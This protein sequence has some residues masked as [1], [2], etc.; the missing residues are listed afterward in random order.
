[1]AK[2]SHPSMKKNEN[3]KAT[4]IPTHTID[5]AEEEERMMF[6]EQMQEIENIPPVN[7]V[8]HDPFAE[9]ELEKK[10]V[11]EKIL[12][13]RQP[14]VKV[15]T[16]KGVKFSL[17]I[18]NA[19]DNDAVFEKL[20]ALKQS[21]QMSRSPVMI[22]AAAIMDIDGVKIEDL[23]DGPDDIEDLLLK[24]YYEV[25]RWPSPLTKSLTRAYNKFSENLDK[26]FDNDFLDESPK[27]DT[28]E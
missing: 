3:I 5:T 17:K 12:L 11:L 1:M 4:S 9:K 18:L 25:S 22:L 10:N 28:T 20:L 13:F 14:Y 26:E 7:E 8:L 21:E 15:V 23:Y 2:M 27:T 19:N 24:K 16:I 6:E